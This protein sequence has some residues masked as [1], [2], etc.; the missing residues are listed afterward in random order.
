MVHCELETIYWEKGYSETV[1]GYTI[2]NKVFAGN[3]S[4]SFLQKTSCC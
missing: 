3:T 4:D 2:I 1:A